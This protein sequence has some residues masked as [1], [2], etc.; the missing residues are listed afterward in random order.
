MAVKFLLDENIEH[1]VLHRLEKLDYT[2]E[3]VEFHP[4][5]GKGTDDTPIAKFSQE[6]E[7]VIVTY[8]PDFVTDHNQSD[9][10]GTVYF[11]DASLSAKQVADVLHT[12]TS[13]YPESAFEGLEFG[14]SEWL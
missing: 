11:E 9:Y 14:S 7:W 10:F 4:E 2:A 3:H 13:H 1:E 8:D 6:N 12:M 5:L